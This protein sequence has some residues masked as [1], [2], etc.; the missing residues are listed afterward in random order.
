[1]AVDYGCFVV[2]GCEFIF[3]GTSQAAFE[4]GSKVRTSKD[5]LLALASARCVEVLTIQADFELNSWLRFLQTT[6]GL[7]ILAPGEGSLVITVSEKN[8][9]PSTQNRG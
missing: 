2:W 5:G 4:G 6:K 8:C 7:Q 9:L 1:M 3:L